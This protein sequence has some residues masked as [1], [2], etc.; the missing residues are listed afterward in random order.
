MKTG[1]SQVKVLMCL[2]STDS[3]LPV[4]QPADVS[5][6]SPTGEGAKEHPG[7]NSLRM[8]IPIMSSHLHHHH[9]M[10]GFNIG[11]WKERGIQTISEHPPDN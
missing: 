9:M 2:A 4:L 3:H 1:K 10:L 11:I 8:L 6:C 7:A 5:L